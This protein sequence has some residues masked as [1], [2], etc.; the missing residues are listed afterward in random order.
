MYDMVLGLAAGT[1]AVPAKAAD[2]A[3]MPETSELRKQV[4]GGNFGLS[5]FETGTVNC[6]ANTTATVVTDFP[7][8][9]VSKAVLGN[10]ISSSVYVSAGRCQAGGDGT[11]GRSWW[12]QHPRC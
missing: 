4:R 2:D 5:Q 12:H 10:V 8:M 9:L 7:L 3:V 11:P 6:H 1:S